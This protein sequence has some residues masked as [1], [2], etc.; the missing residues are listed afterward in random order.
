MKSVAKSEVAPANENATP[1]RKSIRFLAWTLYALI[2]GLL[3]FELLLRWKT[4]DYGGQLRIGNT[5]LLPYDLVPRKRRDVLDLDPDNPQVMRYEVPDA[6]LGWTIRPNG[7]VSFPQGTQTIEYAAN[8]LGMRSAPREL[9]TPKPAGVRRMLVV[10]DSFAHGDEVNWSDTWTAQ[11]ELALGPPNE[12]W[13]GGVPGYGTDQAV[14]RFERLVDLVRPDVAVLVI[15]RQDLLR[16]LTFF[17]CLQNPQTGLSWSKPRFIAR[18]SEL[19]L[20]N[21]P[22]VPPSGVEA[23]LRGYGEHPLSR[24]D[25]FWLPEF[26]TGH[27]ADSLRTWR[28]FR[29][30]QAVS[31]FREESHRLLGQDPEARELLVSLS[32]RFESGARA[33]GADPAILILPDHVDVAEA[34]QGGS[35]FMRG[36]VDDL[37]NAQLRVFSAAEALASALA[38]GEPAEAL[39]V[40]GDGHPN[41]RANA[42]IAGYLREAL[43]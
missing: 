13:N 10:G 23:V 29:S 34:R 2:L 18:G 6:N 27:W 21:S 9:V 31:R 7:R 42:V 37:R 43:R 15:Y 38:P 17:R 1:V 22:V 5:W 26:F 4:K 36:V 32:R 30:T 12:V 20:M 16:N 11:W 8:S 35:G 24:H 25:R 40:G 3:P 19:E 39:F 33:A 28:W 14:L 41:P